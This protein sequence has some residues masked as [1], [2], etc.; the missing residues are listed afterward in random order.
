LL[1]GFSFT[2]RFSGNFIV[3]IAGQVRDA[4]A[5]DGVTIQL[6][7]GTGT[8]PSTAAAATGTPAGAPIRFVS[9]VTSTTDTV[10]F[11][12]PCLVKGL[13]VGTAAWFDLSLLQVTGG[14]VAIQDINIVIHEVP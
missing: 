3:V 14:T 11:C 2:P 10:G 4:T 6:R 8:A 9:G 7:F 5:A 12:I 1:S 13:T